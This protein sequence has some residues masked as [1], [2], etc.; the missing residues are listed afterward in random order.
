MKAVWLGEMSWIYT[1]LIL[2]ARICV[3]SLSMEFTQDM[4]LKSA[5]LMVVFVL[6]MRVRNVCFADLRICQPLNFLRNSDVNTFGSR[7]LAEL[8]HEIVVL[9]SSSRGCSVSQLFIALD[10]PWEGD[11][12]KKF[13]STE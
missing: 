5:I 7:D 4:G 1:L 10:H 6:G 11:R 9:T 3:I 13:N 2:S 8:N 12:V